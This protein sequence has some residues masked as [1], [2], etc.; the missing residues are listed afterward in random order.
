MLD[1]H[2]RRVQHRPQV[3]ASP[4]WRAGFVGGAFASC[5]S[6]VVSL[7]CFRIASIVIGMFRKHNA[8]EQMTMRQGQ[9]YSSSQYAMARA[10]RQVL[11]WQPV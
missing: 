11:M 5:I 2:Q 6:I 10:T 7:T 9:Y 8:H 4:K 1:N 3:A